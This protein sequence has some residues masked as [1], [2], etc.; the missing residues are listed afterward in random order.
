M[1][2]HNIENTSNSAPLDFSKI[3]LGIKRLDDA[4]LNLGTYRTIDSRYGNKN[5]VL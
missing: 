2:R 5:F 1:K 4:I 3:Q